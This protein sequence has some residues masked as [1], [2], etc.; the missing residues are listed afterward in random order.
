MSK[1]AWFMD[2]SDPPQVMRNALFVNTGTGRF[3]EVAQM[4]GVADSDWTWSLKFGDFD[5]DGYNDLFISNGMTGDWLNSDLL[6]QAAKEGREGRPDE[7]PEKRDKHIAFRNLG[8]LKFGDVG[9][10]WGLDEAAIGFGAAMGDLD[11][12][13]DLDLVVNNFDDAP[14]IFRNRLDRGNCIKIALRGTQSNRHG[15]DS[16]VTMEAGELKQAFYVT[17]ARGFMGCDEP[18]VHF[19]LG[20]RDRIDKL[21]IRW[22]SGCV[23]TLD[24]LAANRFYTIREPVVSAEVSPEIPAENKTGCVAGPA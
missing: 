10:A 22:P 3:L 19:G 15:I 11:N 5:C 20:D 13:G 18:V 8:D 21:T 2:L 1:D 7:V 9:K 17:L 16:V 6:I 12:D 24:A 14:S 23:Q 4:A